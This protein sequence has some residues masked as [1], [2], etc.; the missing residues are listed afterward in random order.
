MRTLAPTL[1]AAL[2]ICLTT[3]GNPANS[4]AGAAAGGPT[5]RCAGLPCTPS[6]SFPGVP[7]GGNWTVTLLSLTGGQG[8]ETCEPCAPCKARVSWSAEFDEDTEW[9]VDWGDGDASGS[10]SGSGS[11]STSNDCNGKGNADTFTGGGET[12]TGTLNCLCGFWG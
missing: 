9:S 1:F 2:A 11:F 12:L 7:V 3:S 6:Y 10:G 5:P 8:F 4:Q